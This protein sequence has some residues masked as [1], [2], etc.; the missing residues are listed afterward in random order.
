MFIFIHQYGRYKMEKNLIKKNLT[1]KKRIYSILQVRWHL[2]INFFV[3]FSNVTL[4][5]GSKLNI[6][7]PTSTTLI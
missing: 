7:R 3:R 6:S 5:G 4:M 2:S 1:K